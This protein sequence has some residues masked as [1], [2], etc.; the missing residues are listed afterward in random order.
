MKNT[1]IFAL[2]LSLMAFGCKKFLDE[3]SDAKLA[4]PQSLEDLQA[5]LNNESS[6]N[7]VDPSAQEVCSDDYYVL[8]ADLN[9]LFLEQERR[10]YT[11]QKTNLFANTGVANEWQGLY[12]LVYAANTVLENLEKIGRT[13]EKVREFDNI[14]GQ[15]LFN[16]ARAYYNILQVWS[17]GYNREIAGNAPGMVI[18]TS[19][20]FNEISVRSSLQLSYDY[21]LSDLKAASALLAPTTVN[22]VRPSKQAALG[23]LARVYLGMSDYKNA[24]LHADSCIRMKSVLLDYNTLNSSATFPIPRFNVEVI[25]D[26]G[27]ILPQILGNTRAKIVP[28]LYNSYH[29]N[30]LRK[31][32][33]FRNNNNGSFGWRGNYRAGQGMFPGLAIDEQFLIRAECNARLGNRQNALDDLNSLLI[34]RFKTGTFKPY[35][36]ATIADLNELIMLERRKELL[37]RGLRW[38]DLKRYNLDGAN[39]ELLRTANGENYSLKANDSRYALEIPQDVVLLSGIKQ[40]P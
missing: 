37:M 27:S 29:D 5:I 9:S 2:M 30:D 22:P 18:R 4:V 33:F 39:I 28:L 20:D 32:L 23:Y 8:D 40:N 31:Q 38:A 3:K 13:P 25:Y 6:I 1:I 7:G 11:W 16:R 12:S 24:F 26:C 15:A 36:L 14:K 34:K 21:V 35:G 17:V 10:L 19:T